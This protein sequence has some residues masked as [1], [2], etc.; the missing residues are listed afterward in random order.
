M[1]KEVSITDKT[2]KTVIYNDNNPFPYKPTSDRIILDI[3]KIEPIK[4]SGLIL[5]EKA[6]N[7][8]KEGFFMEHPFQGKVVAIGD[9]H[10]NG[11]QTKIEVKVGD[12]VALDGPPQDYR[13][14]II[15]EGKSYL[16][17]RMGNILGIKR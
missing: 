16:I 11:I 1:A 13:T 3:I 14:I 8:N 2:V 15:V 10:I 7:E 9:G 6:Q 12:V 5:S 4:K 17:V